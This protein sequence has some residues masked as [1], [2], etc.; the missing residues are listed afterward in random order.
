MPKQDTPLLSV[1]VRRFNQHQ[2]VQL[3]QAIN[4]IQKEVSQQ[5]G[6][7]GLQNSFSHSKNYCE[8]V[9]VFTFDSEESLEN[10]KRS[11][12]RQAFVE[13]LDKYSHGDVTHAQF[14]NLGLL[15]P[16]KA[17]LRKIEMIVILIFWI[18]LLGAG[19][20]HLTNT[21]IPGIL[22]PFIQNALLISTSVLLISYFFL[23]W[24]SLQ[25]IKLKAHLSTKNHQNQ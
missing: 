17:Q 1:I 21:L 16:E 12:T 6:F 22:N 13:R 14:D 25:I 11:S 9:T 3:Q 4:N 18:L 10:W 23:P 8:L 15:L 7:V 24:S 5:A 2:E 20:R 19:L